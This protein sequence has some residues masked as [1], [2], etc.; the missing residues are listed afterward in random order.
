MSQATHVEEDIKIDTPK[1]RRSIKSSRIIRKKGN[2]ILI[3]RLGVFHISLF[4]EK[5][6]NYIGY[7]A[8]Q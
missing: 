3:I 1:K 4:F 8:N 2:F 7:K 6:S 5:T